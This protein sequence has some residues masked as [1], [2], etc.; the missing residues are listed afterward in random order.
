MFGGAGPWDLN[1]PLLGSFSLV[2]GRLL[3]DPAGGMVDG[4]FRDFSEA[5]QKARQIR[6]CFYY[7]GQG[8]RSARPLGSYRGGKPSHT[9]E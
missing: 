9:T 5:V 7:L 3:R 4:P 2:G 6:T 8:G 1:P